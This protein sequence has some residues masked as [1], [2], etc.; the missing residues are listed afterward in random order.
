MMI[1]FRVQKKEREKAKQCT[2]VSLLP[3]LARLSCLPRFPGQLPAQLYAVQRR[4][5][6]GKKH[7][8][9]EGIPRLGQ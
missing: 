6:S 2:K 8:Q 4:T 5:S 3:T 1:L 7:L 9:Q